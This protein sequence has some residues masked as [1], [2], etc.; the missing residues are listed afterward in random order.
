MVGSYQLV[1]PMIRLPALDIFLP[2]LGAR[3]QLIGPIHPVNSG[4]YV[5][6]VDGT[7]LENPG[8]PIIVRSLPR[9]HR[10]VWVLLSLNCRAVGD[11]DEAFAV[12]LD[13]VHYDT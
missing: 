3:G 13:P 5:M 1:T 11:E 4:I 8:N 10:F 2:I 7:D 12:V 9:L 6:F